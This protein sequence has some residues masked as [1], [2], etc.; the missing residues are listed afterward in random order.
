MISDERRLLLDAVVVELRQRIKEGGKIQLNF[1]CTHNS[2]RSH[3]SQIWAQVAAVEN[4]FDQVECYSGGTEATA[5]FPMIIE[6]L[7]KQGLIIVPLSKGENPIYAVK[8]GK[9]SHPLIAFSKRYD[10]SFN[11][12]SDYIA[13]MTCTHADENCPLVVGAC[14]RFALTYIDPKVSDNTTSQRATY[15]ERSEQIRAEM[16]YIFS[17]LKDEH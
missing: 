8:V 4:G 5:V 15:R 16:S 13:I 12:A 1:I 17:K 9:E 14:K 3:L 7:K 2:R 6:T 10:H 11:P